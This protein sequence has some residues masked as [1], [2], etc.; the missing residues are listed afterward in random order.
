M[1]SA[2]ARNRTWVPPDL[3]RWLLTT[4]PQGQSDLS[5]Y[6]KLHVFEI[7]SDGEGIEGNK[8]LQQPPSLPIFFS[9]FH[10]LSLFLISL[11]FLFSLF[12]FPFP[13]P[14]SFPSLSF[15]RTFQIIKIFLRVRLNQTVPKFDWYK[16][17][18]PRRIAFFLLYVYYLW[19]IPP[20]YVT[21]SALFRV[22]GYTA[23]HDNWVVEKS[24]DEK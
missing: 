1:K 13:Y 12:P 21:Q 6:K 23:L 10:P 14:P 19:R 7:F 17:T 20:W 22:G 4:R 15:L 8:A 24:N 16:A 3:S 11:P 5:G 2:P 18:F 9:S